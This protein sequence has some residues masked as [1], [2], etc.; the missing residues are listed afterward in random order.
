M[1]WSGI[2]LPLAHSRHRALRRRRSSRTRGRR[3][4]PLLPVLAVVLI[5]G[6]A[7]GLWAYTTRDD[8][9][10]D[11]LSLLIVGLEFGSPTENADPRAV[12]PLRVSTPVPNP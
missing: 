8:F 10:S 11:D 9:S 3:I 5:G 12:A 1:A 6:V 4:R 7:F 2:V